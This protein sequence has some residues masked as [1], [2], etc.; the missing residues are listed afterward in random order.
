M[1]Y[2]LSLTLL[3]LFGCTN[4]PVKINQGPAFHVMVVKFGDINRW[5]IHATNDNW[6]TSVD[7][8]DAFDISETISDQRACYQTM[9]FDD[10]NSAVYYAARFSSWKAVQTAND[11]AKQRYDSIISFY[12]KHPLPKQICDSIQIK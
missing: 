9:L 8:M 12:A 3:I 11:E 6:G 2:L 4:K 1:K 7:I 5:C 10:C